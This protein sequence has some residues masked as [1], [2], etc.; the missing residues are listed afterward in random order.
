MKTYI[1]INI[2]SHTLILLSVIR[3]HYC[4]SILELPQLQMPYG[5][6]TDTALTFAAQC[7]WVELAE[8]KFCI[9]TVGHTIINQ[10]DG[11]SISV[12]LWQ[13]ILTSYIV[14]CQPAWA[15][16]IPFGRKEA[17]IMMNEEEQRC[18]DEAGLMNSIDVSVV[19]WWDH[20][21]KTER[22]KRDEFKS[23][24]GRKGEFLT[25]SYEESRTGVKPDWRSLETNLVGY[26]ILSQKAEDCTERIL[27]EVKASSEALRN[28]AC[29]ITRNEWDTATR[30]N[31]LDRYF[32]YLWNISGC[33]VCLA[34]IDVHE[35]SPHIPKDNDSGRWETVQVPFSAFKEKFHKVF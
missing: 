2:V 14:S 11:R 8:S 31:N 30:T 4:D 6:K 19:Q 25:L 26:D 10:F 29:I 3:K 1:S 17:Y 22:L 5:T 34:I 9:T 20:L 13:E 33:N 24:L 18:F 12:S 21:A 35:M 16:R 23:K 15:R 27:V 32:F 7:K 28:A